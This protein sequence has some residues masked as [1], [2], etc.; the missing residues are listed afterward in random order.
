MIF[1]IRVTTE[2]PPERD[3]P[4]IAR[5]FAKPN[6][7]LWTGILNPSPGMHNYFTIKKVPTIL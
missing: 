5:E 3:L 7:K 4:Y 2:V 6:G 1:T